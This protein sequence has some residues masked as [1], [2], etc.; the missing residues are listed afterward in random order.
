NLAKT[1]VEGQSLHTGAGLR[2]RAVA[3]LLGKES[4]SSTE[5]MAF[6]GRPKSS[7]VKL[8]GETRPRSSMNT[9]L[10]PGAQSVIARLMSRVPASILLSFV[11]LPHTRLPP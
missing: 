10:S 5:Q 8:H 9:K 4:K 2:S 7:D 3:K 11:S 1:R 6:S